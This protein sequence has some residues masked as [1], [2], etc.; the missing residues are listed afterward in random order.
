[1]SDI[2]VGMYITRIPNRSSPPAVLLRESYREDGKVKSRTLANLS[3]LPDPQIELMRRVLKGEALVA[4]EDAF[5]IVRSRPHGHVAAVLGTLRRL[6]LHHGLSKSPTRVRRVV[7]A[8]IVARI[9]DP[10]S[11]L[12]TARGLGS[13]TQFSS[14]G[15]RLDLHD[16]ET[17]EL[18][19]AMDWLLTRQSRIEKAL[20]KRHLQ[21]GTLVLYDLT[22]SYFEG[23]TCPLAKRGHSRDRKKGTLQ[24]VFGLLCSPD[25]CPIA[26][27][28]FE[29]NTGDPKTVASQVDKLRKRFGLTRLVMVGDRGMLTEA[30]L[31]EDVRPIEG[32][33]WISALRNPAIRSLVDRGSLQLS[34]FDEKD[35]AEIEDPEFPGERLIVCRNPWL[36]K[37]RAR[38]REDLLQATEKELDKIV[39]A[40]TRPTRPFRGKDKIGVRVGKVIDKYKMAKH[41][42]LTITEDRFH[43]QRKVENI[44]NEAALDGI[45]VIRTDV[46]RDTL[47][48]EDAVRSYKGLSVVERAFRSFKSV[49]LKVRPIHHRLADRVRAHV[50]LCMLAYYVEW[51][52]RQALAPIL[53]DD[54]DK[55]SSEAKRKSVVQP[56]QRSAKALKKARTKRTEDDL[57]VHSFQTLLQDLATLVIDRVQPKPN[58]LPAFDKLT[59]PTPVQQRALD[60]LG[61]T[62]DV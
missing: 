28:V 23:R 26:V 22:S 3:H 46:P 58:G 61:V 41:F 12:A 30:R 25:G 33:S 11:K 56:A 38:K 15:E 57:P 51:H 53:F 7:E 50:F 32:L 49:D 4:P 48:A 42:D 52:M 5:E 13:E 24:I 18:Y 45:Y 54:N 47:S 17:D 1:M 44:E 21:D 20:A 31:R 39:A 9:L 19:E 62:L 34:L 55:A 59:T 40:T 10:R 8:M 16:L 60:L 43:Y 27:E 36:A 29:G 35:L 14:L 37:E 2:Q 6:G